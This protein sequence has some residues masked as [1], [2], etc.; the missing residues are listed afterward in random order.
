VDDLVQFGSRAYF[1]FFLLLLF[2]RSM[3]FLSTWIATPNLVL[4][5]NPLARRLSWRWGIPI[6]LLFC[7]IFAHMPLAAIIIATTSVL[8]AARN[9]Q[10]AWLM[11]SY[12][13]ENYRAWFLARSHP[14]L[15]VSVLFAGPGGVDRRSWGRADLFKRLARPN[16]IGH[17]HGHSRLCRRRADL[18]SHRPVPASAP[19][20]RQ[21]LT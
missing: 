5:A 2:G 12:G 17:R 7:G 15:P 1:A 3:D 21:I 9:F 18:H 20:A 11:R 13:E 8:V 14:A 10:M 16:P 19:C 6:N 4:E